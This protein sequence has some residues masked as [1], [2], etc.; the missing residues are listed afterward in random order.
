MK[1]VLLTITLLLSLTA[2]TSTEAA[3]ASQSAETDEQKFVRLTAQLETNPLGDADKSV[4]GWLM[5]WATESKDVSVT[6]CDILGPIPGEDVPHGSEILTQYLFGNAA[7]QI[8]H[9]DRK[10][11]QA[12]AQI[13]GVR[14]AMRAYSALLAEDPQAHIAYF[15][16]LLAQERSGTLEA[17]L[18]PLIAQKCEK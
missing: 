7:F 18:V 13:A 2:H 10:K 9:P 14:S 1:H 12:A 15:D 8:A 6:V 5:Q 11:E 16:T 17:S 4:R 3:A